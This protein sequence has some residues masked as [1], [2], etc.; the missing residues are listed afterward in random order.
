MLGKADAAAVLS[1]LGLGTAAK[2]DVGTGVNQLPD[3]NSFQ[4]G[5]NGFGNWFRLP[6]GILLQFGLYPASGS[7]GGIGFPTPFAVSP[8]YSLSPTATSGVM[9]VASGASTTAINNVR[10]FDAAGNTLTN[11]VSW[12]AIGR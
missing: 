2:K 1:Y 7:S 5:S 6:Q 11:G 9:A 12:I 3:M 8:Q 4:S 10:T